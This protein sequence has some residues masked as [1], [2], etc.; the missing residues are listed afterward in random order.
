M[1]LPLHC[2]P[3]TMRGQGTSIQWPEAEQLFEVVDYLS[4]FHSVVLPL[5][6]CLD[7]GQ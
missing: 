6:G 3:V 5:D 2:T 4:C 7:G 1:Q